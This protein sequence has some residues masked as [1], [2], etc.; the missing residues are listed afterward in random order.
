MASAS[1]TNKHVAKL[2][3]FQMTTRLLEE[4]EEAVTHTLLSIAVGHVAGFYLRN[5]SRRP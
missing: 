4:E 1:I 5:A 3:G 2:S